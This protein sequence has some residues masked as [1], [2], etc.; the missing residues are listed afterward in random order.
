MPK[1]ATPLEP[2]V[3]VNAI[4]HLAIEVTD[5]MRSIS[6]YEMV[7]GLKIFLDNRFDLH[8]PSVK[9]LIGGFGIELTQI[10]CA[11]GGPVHTAKA[12]TPGGCPCLSFSIA[13]A[14]RAFQR[15]KAA[16][17]TAAETISVFQG[18]QFFFVTDPD[19]YVFE[20]IEF[21]GTINV[22]GD[23]EPLLRAGADQRIKLSRRIA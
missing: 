15:L 20:L 4:S 21:P 18:A 7:L 17:H 2:L 19:G 8:L 10:E 22:L 12:G 11:T 13:D 1:A 5:L 14:A 3:T 9:G 6:F 23:L 16:G